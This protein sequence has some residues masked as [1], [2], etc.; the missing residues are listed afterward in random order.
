LPR[1]AAYEAKVPWRNRHVNILPAAMGIKR[2][3]KFQVPKV[4]AATLRAGFRF[5]SLPAK[6]KGGFKV[7][8]AH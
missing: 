2:S 4:A 8:T 3:S 6:L 1:R 7:T 5:Q